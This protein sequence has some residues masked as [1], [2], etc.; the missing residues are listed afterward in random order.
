MSTGQTV[1][2][3]PFEMK[4]WKFCDALILYLSPWLRTHD[5]DLQNIYWIGATMICTNIDAVFAFLLIRCFL[6]KIERNK[7]LNTS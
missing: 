7:I 4:K 5:L 1:Y 6:Q 2:E 3:Y